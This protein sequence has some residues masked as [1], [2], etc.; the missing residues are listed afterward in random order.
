MPIQAGGPQ[1]VAVITQESPGVLVAQAAE[2]LGVSGP[3]VRS[4]MQRGALRTVPGATPAQIEPESLRRVTRGIAELR[5]RG[6]DRDWLLALVDY[7]DDIN[8]RRNPA[9]R[10]GLEQLRR[11]DYEPA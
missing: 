2:H 5:E 8:V 7:L 11:G 3:T 4:W 9:L 6:Q 1:V 10:E